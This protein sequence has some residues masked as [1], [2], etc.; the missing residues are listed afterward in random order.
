MKNDP[1]VAIISTVKGTLEELILFINYHLN[2]GID[3]IILFFDDPND[4]CIDHIHSTYKNV[5]AVTCTDEYWLKKSSHRPE[6]HTERQVINANEGITIAKE[7]GCKWIIH[8][9]RDELIYSSKNFKSV[10][11]NSESDVIRLS[12]REAIPEIENYKNIFEPR[13]FKVPNPSPRKVK[14][15]KVFGCKSVFYGN[16]YFKGHTRSKV[17]IKMTSKIQKIAIHQPLEY[18][19]ENT[20]FTDTQEI[21]LLHFDSIGFHDWYQKFANKPENFSKKTTVKRGAYRKLLIQEFVDARDKGSQHLRS[22]YKKK[23]MISRN[24]IFILSLLK[25]TEKISINHKFF[26]T[27][28]R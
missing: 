17:A 8:I 24:K 6:L 28:S 25:M 11:D 18:D 22:L 19:K 26:E 21:K 14:I 7:L 4:N 10:L 12:I 3:K 23:Y 13:I 9:D 15:A 20:R 2:I 1:K 27:P 16:N 5:H